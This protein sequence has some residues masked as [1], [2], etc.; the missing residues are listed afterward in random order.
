MRKGRERGWKGCRQR[1]H[2]E[3]TEREETEEARTEKE[4][5]QTQPLI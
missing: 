2:A 5:E 4:L 3:E 1:G